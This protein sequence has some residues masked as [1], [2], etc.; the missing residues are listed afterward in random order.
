MR[1]GE[2]DFP[3]EESIGY[4]IRVAHRAYIQD[5]Q[6]RLSEHDIPIGM[7]YFLRAL[8]EKDGLTQIELSDRTGLMGPTT[9]EQLRNMERLGYIVRRRDKTDRRKVR[10]FL[11]SKGRNLR[12]ELIN[13]ARE[14]SDKALQRFSP[15]E[16]DLLKSAIL[17]I[18]A[19]F[20]GPARA[21]SDT[22]S[23]GGKPAPATRGRRKKT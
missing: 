4:L 7:W 10:V 9:A 22:A 8:W 1:E 2:H 6:A 5:L 11:S 20:N 18:I 21:P 23:G 17:R 3:P 13:Y 19:N 14:N 12:K 16:V 15:K